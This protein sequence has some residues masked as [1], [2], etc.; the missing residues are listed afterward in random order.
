MAQSAPEYGFGSGGLWRW[1]YATLIGRRHQQ[2]TGGVCEDAVCVRLLDE[3]SDAGSTQRGPDR[4]IHIALA[5]G[6]S[7]GA[8]GRVAAQAYV[9]HCVNWNP[10]GAHDLRDWLAV[11][12]DRQVRAALR[13]HT[14]EPGASTGAAAWIDA[15]GGARIHRIGDCR[16]YLWCA[17]QDRPVVLKQI[18]ADQTMAYMGYVDADSPRAAQPSHMVGNGNAGDPEFVTLHM[19]HSGGLLLC[20]DGFHE[21]IRQAALAAYLTTLSGLFEKHGA[22]YLGHWCECLVRQAK[23]LGTNDDVS[24][25]VLGKSAGRMA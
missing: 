17:A 15:Q 6:V 22:A 7:G 18:M 19:P 10:L 25:L 11:Q 24:V 3:P 2:Q 12:A 14:R 8:C 4:A 1:G 13:L 23:E 5:D 9:H 20:S 21:V 16:A